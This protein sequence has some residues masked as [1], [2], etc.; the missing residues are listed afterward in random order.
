MGRSNISGPCEVKCC[1]RYKLTR[2]QVSRG[3]LQ[4]RYGK[5]LSERKLCDRYAAICGRG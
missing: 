4:G 2:E 1:K 5:A 3:A